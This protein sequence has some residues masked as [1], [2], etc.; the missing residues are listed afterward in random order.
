[1]FAIPS[2][3]VALVSYIGAV[4]LFVGE[5]VGKPELTAN[6]ATTLMS[7]VAFVTA[8]LLAAIYAVFSCSFYLDLFHSV[9]FRFGAIN[10]WGTLS[11]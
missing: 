10:L 1:M 6:R 9:F 4:A 11:C 8:S 2:A 7:A 3:L 5:F